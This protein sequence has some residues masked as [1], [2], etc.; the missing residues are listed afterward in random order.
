MLLHE[1]SRPYSVQRDESRDAYL[2]DRLPDAVI[3]TLSCAAGPDPVVHG[4]CG[5]R[6]RLESRVQRCHAIAIPQ[7]EV[8]KLHDD[9]VRIG[10]S[11]RNRE[12]A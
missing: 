1:V 6:G 7:V 5:L 8:R 11:G 10:G 4:A 9:L 3:D 12:A 2:G